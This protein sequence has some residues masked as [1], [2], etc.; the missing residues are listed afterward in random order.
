LPVVSDED[1]EALARDE[2][3]RAKVANSLG[4]DRFDSQL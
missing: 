3:Q 4:D 2:L 1:V